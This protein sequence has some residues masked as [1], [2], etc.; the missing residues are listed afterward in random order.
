MVSSQS[1][2]G[3]PSSSLEDSLHHYLV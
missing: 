1:A 2:S 3:Q